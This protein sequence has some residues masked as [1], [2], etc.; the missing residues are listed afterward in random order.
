VLQAELARDIGFA[1]RCRWRVRPR[2]AGEGGE[3]DHAVEEVIAVDAVA[4]VAQAGDQAGGIGQPEGGL[5][6]QRA[7]VTSARSVVSLTIERGTG[8]DGSTG[9][10]QDGGDGLLVEGR[11]GIEQ[12]D[13]VLEAL[14]GRRGDAQLLRE[15]LRFLVRGQVADLVVP[16]DMSID[17]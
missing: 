17:A 10:R 8:G 13:H 11:V 5:A 6:E 16:S 2:R 4:R 7:G 15:L 3:A 14:L 1:W 12:A 9:I